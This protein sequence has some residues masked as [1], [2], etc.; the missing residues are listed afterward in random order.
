MSHYSRAQPA[1]AKQFIVQA[2]IVFKEPAAN[3]LFRWKLGD[4]KISVKTG[5]SLKF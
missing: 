5:T 3:F 1:K 4:A 2:F